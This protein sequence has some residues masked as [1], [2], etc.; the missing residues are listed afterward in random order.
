MELYGIKTPLIKPGDDIVEILVKSMNEINF[1][2]EDKDI[3]VLA[4]SAVA[5]AENRVINFGDIKPSEKAIDLGKQYSI[6]PG[7]MEV[8]LQESDKIICGIPEFVLTLKNGFLL[9]NAGIDASNAPEG[10]V[11]PLPENPDKSA[12]EIR[13]KFEERYNCN[14]A[15]ILSDSRTHPLRWGC[16]GIAIGCSGIEAVEDVRGKKDIYGKPLK[17][18]R[19]AVA[20]NI[21]SAAEIMMGE[22]NE[23]VPMVVVRGA[24][25]EIKDA[26]GIPTISPEECLYF[27]II[28]KQAIVP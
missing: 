24:P 10:H 8:I 7:E 25:V 20:D 17:I 2:L 18:T 5:T 16:I 13:I 15:V 11:I 4:E 26:E 3:V 6:D 21:A 14:I 9:P 19:K 22:A 12:S 1:E 27:G 28:S 23:S